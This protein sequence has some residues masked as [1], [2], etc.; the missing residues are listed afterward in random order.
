[1]KRTFWVLV[2]L[3]IATIMSGF[4]QDSNSATVTMYRQKRTYGKMVKPSI[5]SDGVELTRLH[6]GTF[7]VASLPPGCFNAQAH[8]AR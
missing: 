2:A 1:M 6:N 8:A 4:G 5:Y 7:F 3:T